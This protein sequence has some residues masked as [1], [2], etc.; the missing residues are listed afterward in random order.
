MA[1]DTI[2][3]QLSLLPGGGLVVS[4]GEFGDRLVDHARR[5]LLRFE[6]LRVDWGL[7]VGRDLIEAALDRAAGAN[8]LWA[9]H[10]ETST[11]VLNDLEM[12]KDLCAARDIR[13][14]VDC[15][16]SIGTVP[17]D[18]G[19]VYLGSCVSGKGLGAYPGLSMVFHDHEVHPAPDALPRYLDLGLH[20]V[21]AGVPFT[22]SSNLIYALDAALVRFEAG[23]GIHLA[24][25]RAGEARLPH[26][27]PRRPLV[28]RGDHN[29]A[30]RGSAHQ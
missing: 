11:G 9:V 14:A 1:N 22:M 28:A 25:S 18:L 8:W 12:L 16:S 20:A 7:P 15:I 29:R 30:S 23:G 13:L 4:S 27:G 6:V 24:P 3:D 10:C 2:A 17:V 5:M 19:G 26:R 21:K